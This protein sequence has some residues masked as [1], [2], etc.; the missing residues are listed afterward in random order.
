MNRTVR[1][2][3]STASGLILLG[4]GVP[5]AS[6]AAGATAGGVGGSVIHVVHS[7][8]AQVNTNQSSNW[9]GYNIGADYPQVTTGTTF[10]AVSGVWKVPKA[11]Q[12]TSGEAE[13]SAT[14][15]G[16]GGGCIDDACT[17]TDNTLIQAGTEQDVSAT[18]QASYSAWWEIIPEPQTT[19]SLP[20]SAGNKIKVTIGQTSTPGM[21]LIVIKNL[22]TGQQFSITTPYSSSMDTVEWIEETPLEI[23]TNGTGLAH[24]PN[25]SRVHFSKATYNGANPKFQAID[26]LQLNNNGMI[27]ATPS[28]PNAA[29]NG[30][31]DCTWSTSCPA[32]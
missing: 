15:T 2:L 32:P 27:E 29:L 12:H 24:M 23:G 31:N 25:L 13:S 6:A 18:G 10:T 20:V 22:S 9:S 21:W 11:T 1:R 14:W 26:E 4:L 8:G 28:A 16:I 7:A 19:V 3:A 30:F 17:A 5:A